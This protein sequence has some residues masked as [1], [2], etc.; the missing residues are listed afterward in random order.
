L[1]TAT[2]YHFGDGRINAYSLEGEFLG[3]LKTEH[4]VIEIDELWAITFP[5]VSATTIDKNRLYFAA[6]P[7]EEQDGLF[8]YIVKD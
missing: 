1:E 4:K 3:Q 2:C 7:D 5:P 8:G 6:G